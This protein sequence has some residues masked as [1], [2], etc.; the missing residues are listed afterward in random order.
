VDLDS[1]HHYGKEKEKEKKKEQIT[2]HHKK[3]AFTEYYR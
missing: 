1:T 3:P 2:S